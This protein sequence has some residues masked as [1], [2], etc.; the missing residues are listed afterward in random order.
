[1]N[2]KTALITGASSG[3]GKEF[4]K[5]HAANG[6]NI[7]IVARRLEKLQQLKEELETKHNINVVVI[8][9]DLTQEH[10]V[11]ELYDEVKAKNISVDYLINNAGF[12]GI[13]EFYK[14]D[15][16]RNL[17]MI[18][19]NIMVL[20][21]L[22]ALFLADFV[23]RNSGRILNVSST[24]S[25]MPGPL[26]SVYYASKAYVTSFS[27][28]ISEEIRKTNVTVTTLLPGPTATEFGEISKMDKTVLFD[29]T[30]SAEKVARDGYNA[31]L[32]G[33]LDVVS[34]VNFKLK[35]LMKLIPFAPKKFV[36]NQV[37]KM[38]QLT[39]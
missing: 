27:Y 7:I 25:W 17:D 11:Q 26:Q 3:L 23:E 21:E 4:A 29:Q 13:G 37:Y 28:A 22:T 16:N 19:L 36:L 33:K 10:A 39:K 14:Q 31:M 12:G 32:K 15:I 35:L 1:M 34:G 6:G 2:K 18:K 30:S 24:A 8:S 20:T 9:K 5:I 38:Q